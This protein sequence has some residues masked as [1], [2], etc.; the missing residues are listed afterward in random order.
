MCQADFTKLKDKLNA[1]VATLDGEALK[2]S[3]AL[4]RG[5][6]SPLAIR[7]ANDPAG[8]AAVIPTAA[9][10]PASPSMKE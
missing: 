2:G 10:A 9:G 8:A 7:A 5:S 6:T 3:I 4:K 1:G